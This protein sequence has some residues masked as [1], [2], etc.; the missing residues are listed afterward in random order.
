MQRAAGQLTKRPACDGAGRWALR[1]AWADLSTHPRQTR[2]PGHSAS[3]RAV[4]FPKRR[5]IRP[6]RLHTALSIL[7]NIG[8]YPERVVK[9]SRCG[10]SDQAISAEHGLQLRLD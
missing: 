6:R 10:Y 4:P 8:C 1:S 9:A 2:S 7:G 3:E 5:I